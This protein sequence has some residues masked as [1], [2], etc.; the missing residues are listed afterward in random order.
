M[1]IILGCKQAGKDGC[2][3]WSVVLVVGDEIYANIQQFIDS[4]T[5]C[6]YQFNINYRGA[7]HLALRE[8]ISNLDR[9]EF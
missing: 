2:V 9:D 6:N 7:V 4:D 1:H 5:C 3:G 8:H